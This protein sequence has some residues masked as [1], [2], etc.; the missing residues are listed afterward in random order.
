MTRHVKRYAQERPVGRIGKGRGRAGEKMWGQTAKGIM[1][2]TKLFDAF[3]LHKINDQA[4]K[5][6][7]RGWAHSRRA[8]EGEQS[9]G[10]QE[11]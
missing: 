4:R 7:T 6:V 10:G 3:I 8:G 1:V 2:M 11:M 5:K 9:K